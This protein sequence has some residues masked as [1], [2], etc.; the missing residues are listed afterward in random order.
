MKASCNFMMYSCCNI[1]TGINLQCHTMEVFCKFL[2]EDC[3]LGSKTYSTK[4]TFLFNLYCLYVLK[5]VFLSSVYNVG[6]TVILYCI[7]MCIKQKM[8]IH[9][10]Y[11]YI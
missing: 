10:A 9:K 7:A 1:C 8:R 4:S 3:Y 6:A 2:H 11:T 5:Q